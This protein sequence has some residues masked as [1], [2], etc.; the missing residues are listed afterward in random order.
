MTDKELRQ[1]ALDYVAGKVYT[2]GDVPQ[3]LWHMVFMP[4]AFAKKAQL[5]GVRMV[6]ACVGEDTATGQ[7]INGFPIFFSCKMLKMRDTRKFTGFVE[8]ARQLTGKF[9]NHT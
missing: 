6:L 5:R 9:V 8:E 1:L 2:T 7:A 3:T 4:L